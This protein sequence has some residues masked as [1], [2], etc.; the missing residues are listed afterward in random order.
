M[1]EAALPLVAESVKAFAATEIVVAPFA[2]GVKV[3]L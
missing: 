3:A 2:V 1:A